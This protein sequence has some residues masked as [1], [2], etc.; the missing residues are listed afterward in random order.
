MDFRKF[1]SIPDSEILHLTK[2]GMT[3]TFE[4]YSHFMILLKYLKKK[5]KQKTI[6][7]NFVYILYKLLLC[8]VIV[9]F[10]KTKKNIYIKKKRK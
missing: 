9:L 10:N 7:C 1:S 8:Y 5:Q 6:N 3:L 4:E 2:T